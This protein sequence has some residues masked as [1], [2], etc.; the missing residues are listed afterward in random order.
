MSF[1][2]TTAQEV[3]KQPEQAKNSFDIN[4]A[5]VV[6]NEQDIAIKN[7]KALEDITKIENTSEVMQANKSKNEW[8]TR[9]VRPEQSEEWK[10]QGEIDFIEAYKKFDKW[11]MTPYLNAKTIPED[12][13]IV[14]Q[15]K[16]IADGEEVEGQA[17]YDVAEFLQ[18]YAEVETR[19]YSLG[20]NFVNAGLMTIPYMVEAGVALA[21][22]GASTPVTATKT[23]AKVGVKEG[24]KLYAKQALEQ[25]AKQTAKNIAKGTAKVATKTAKSGASAF[26]SGAK[27]TTL[28]PHEVVKGYANRELNNHIAIT[29]KGQVFVKE[30][31]ELPAT[32]FIKAWAG[33][34]MDL[35]VEKAGGE[36]IRKHS[37]NAYN[38]IA[39]GI[40]KASRNYMP[41]K[42]RHA[43][44]AEALKKA[45]R[46][47]SALIKAKDK[48]GFDGLL[49]EMG[50]ERLADILKTTFD[51]DMQQ[52][53]STEQ[54]GNAILPDW[55]TLLIEG[56][57][58]TAR[59]TISVAGSKLSHKLREQG[60]NDNEISEIVTTTSET[61]KQTLLDMINKEDSPQADN[62]DIQLLAHEM[63]LQTDNKKSIAQEVKE[64]K[65]NKRSSI[66][67][68][69]VGTAK[70]LWRSTYAGIVNKMQPIE[71]LSKRAKKA[72]LKIKPGQDPLLLARTYAGNGRQAEVIIQN[73]TFYIN[74]EGN[75]V[76]TG[77][78]LTPIVDDYNKYLERA[79]PKE[80]QR[81]QDLQD[82]L[83]SVRITQDLADNPEVK[84]TEEQ[85]KQSA[86]NYLALM[87]K[88][89]DDFSYLQTTAQRI[90]A[91]QRRNLEMYVH[92]GNMT[93]EQYNDIV[94]KHPNY[95]PFYRVFGEDEKLDASTGK[96][97]RFDKA[98]AHLKK[99]KG[100]ER[101]VEDIYES[102]IKNVYQVTDRA[103]RNKVAQSVVSLKDVFP[104][105]IE[106]LPAP[107]V[108]VG[109]ADIKV[110]YDE[111]L[112]EKLENTIKD[113][114]AK[115]EVKD[116]LNKP[117]QKGLVLGHY[118][119]SEKTV[120]KRLGATER[121]LSHEVGHLLDYEFNIGGNMLADENIK[122]ELKQFA[123]DRLS[124]KQ[125]ADVDSV[126]KKH[127]EYLQNDREVIANL[128]DGYI[129]SPLLLKEQA[130]KA[131]KKLES[132]IKDTEGL[133]VLNDIK[134]SMSAGVE[135][136]HQDIYNRNMFEPA[137]PHITVYENG[138]KKFYKLSE[139]LHNAMTG[140]TDTQMGIL[141][142]IIATPASTLRAGATLTPEFW[143]RNFVRDQFVAYVQ[144]DYGFNPVIDT[145]MALADMAGNKELYNDWLA[146]GGAYSG[147]VNL[148]K[149]GLIKA[150]GELINPKSIPLWKKLNPIK[151]LAKASET[152]EE[153]T[154]LGLYRKAKIKGMSDL[155][156]GLASREGTLDFSRSGSQTK[157]INAW[158]AFLNAQIQGVDKTI[159]IFKNHPVKSTL[160]ATASITLPSILFALN[161]FN[162][163]ETA[164]EY[165]EIPRWRR[166]L[167]WMMK[168]G[169][170]W[171]AIPKPFI[172]GQIYGTAV[173]RFIEYTYTN[174]KQ[175][176]EGLAKTIL[177]ASAPVQGLSNLLPTAMKPAI[178]SMTNYNFFTER[179]IVSEHKT[180][181]E[182]E[183]Q[184]NRYTTET[185]KMLGE[186]FNISP[187]VID[188]SVRGWFG[189]LGMY[190]MQGSDF[191]IKEIKKEQ[192]HEIVERPKELADYPLLRGWVSR[193]VM[194]NNSESVKRFYKNFYD[195]SPISKTGIS[196][197]YKSYLEFEKTDPEKAQEYYEENKLAIEAYEFMSDARRDIA[198]L[199]REI[200]QVQDSNLLM[201]AKKQQIK[202]LAL[203]MTEVAK[204]ANNELKTLTND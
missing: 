77:E 97:N 68:E 116:S 160:K 47:L 143:T 96:K 93:Q 188:N 30:S 131:F 74:D 22:F 36:F 66:P 98:K 35:S 124:T 111:K 105:L 54:F 73:H 154:R 95:I 167:F 148:D 146:S 122:A 139:P 112:R 50:E 158:V 26:A 127:M 147:L 6:N 8:L 23:T 67:A 175:A 189:G 44:D 20:G 61:E 65:E 25:G 125:E 166:D 153:A 106:E 84:V 191:L 133:S 171:V 16:R 184:S 161:N 162:D 141:S 165:L 123:L 190:G 39:P 85:Q 1:D 80:K 56:G 64:I 195:N 168:A 187:A 134:P 100:S 17:R 5:T 11:E 78:G 135:S 70:S 164:K 121:V 142:K 49:T 3:A 128:I 19:G 88:Y 38:A 174:D 145:P 151:P 114:G 94:K 7:T 76:K 126:S 150:Y 21:S 51:L 83:V 72:G 155:E 203:Q 196:T 192:G 58:F 32:S 81:R 82:Y 115:Y 9:V 152:L 14:K 156:A 2:M 27:A 101:E 28:M 172:I 10:R 113:L 199:N 53:Y 79:E 109:V 180:D 202:D 90:Y 130:P 43:L 117:G 75:I 52:G 48:A 119:P 69:S 45:G 163:E 103:Y 173:E 18:D 91:F 194:G 63:A 31:T 4:S 157:E 40:K 34:A 129:N 186:Q 169:D 193:E 182:K 137:E 120:R 140:L 12:L 87:K 29:D 144:S 33:L 138:K 176:F 149:K 46:P 177:D 183:L 159:R 92:S 118:S 13:Y 178:E 185:S 57:I 60:V 104:D 86:E 132:L 55:E 201:E 200:E 110:S 181:L 89:G 99:I 197:K 107:V 102:M 15:L 71:D 42:L 59:G 136:L 37:S 170:E 41:A 204:Q 179:S 24:L 62:T 108:K 198:D